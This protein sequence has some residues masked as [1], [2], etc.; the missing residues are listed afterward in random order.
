M[1]VC[2][3]YKNCLNV[4]WS[5]EVKLMFSDVFGDFVIIEDL[6]NWWVKYG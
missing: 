1:I 6:Y 3:I 5:N 4:I 2:G